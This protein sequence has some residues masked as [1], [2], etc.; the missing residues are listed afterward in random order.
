MKTLN[1]LRLGLL[2]AFAAVSVPALYAD[3]EDDKKTSRGNE[4][5]SRR[6]EQFENAPAGHLQ[7]ADRLIGSP[8]VFAEEKGRAGILEDIVVDL[9]S[10]RALYAIIS[11]GRGNNERDENRGETRAERRAQQREDRES[12]DS[13]LDREDR[14]AERRMGRGGDG[15][16]VPASA[17]R[18]GDGRNFI[19][20]G[21]RTRFESAP[22]VRSGDEAGAVRLSTDIYK[23]YGK[24]VWWNANQ[25]SGNFGNAHRL[26]DLIN[27]EVSNVSNSK[28]GTVD[29]LVIDLPAERVL[30]V[31]FEPD[32]SLD[33]K[34][35]LFALP[36]M[37]F[38]KGTGQFELVSNLDR[39]KMTEGPS[40]TRGE[41]PG[42]N[43][44]SFAKR[45]YSHYGKQAY[46]EGQDKL[47]PTSEE[48]DTPRRRRDRRD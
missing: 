27:A 44:Y 43:D 24:S 25:Q 9:E 29:N 1:F 47:S 28:I 37:A 31:V 4:R 22:K 11:S 16:A 30:Y 14:R 34:N 10:G 33:L 41:W 15:F 36:P 20:Q 5:I 38:T 18:A 3:H 19:V 21:D 6:A 13:A 32:Q 17:L 42:L 26:S 2:T 7:R 45:V 46:F 35:K 8:V 12:R 39:A 40:F 23:H 48:Q